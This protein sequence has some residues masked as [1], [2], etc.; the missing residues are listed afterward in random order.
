[1]RHRGAA[2]QAP[3]RFRTRI[4]RLLEIDRAGK[5]NPSHRAFSADQPTGKG[6]EAQF[7][8][9][10]VFCLGVALD[11]QN[12]GVNQSE[13][14]FLVSHVREPD[15]AG[16]FSE[17]QGGPP[18]HLHDHLHPDNHPDLPTYLNAMGIPIVDVSV[19][20]AIQKVELRE[21]FSAPTQAKL[22]DDIPIDLAPT[23][24]WGGGEL[25]AHFANHLGGLRLSTR[26]ALVVELGF[27]G[28]VLPDFLSQAPAKRR[29]RP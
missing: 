28:S 14:V 4:K 26:S 11:L 3:P 2:L 20:F 22:P 1:M 15:L 12:L 21:L 23:V 25:A 17:I 27:L 29:G 13:A 9:F 7:T 19:Y 6:N 18:R 24:C 8:T 16:A 5:I 10:D